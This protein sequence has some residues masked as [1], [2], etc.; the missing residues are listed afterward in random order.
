MIQQNH[1]DWLLNENL[2][3]RHDNWQMIRWNIFGVL[4]CCSV[5][6]VI[7]LY[8][9]SEGNTKQIIE[10]T[11][12]GSV[13]ASFLGI[14]LLRGLSKFPGVQGSTYI[15]P[16]L[17]TGYSASFI[18]FLFARIQYSRSVFVT[19]FILCAVWFYI[20]YFRAQRRKGLIIGI[21][22]EGAA[23][24]LTSIDRIEWRALTS[25]SADA[26][27]LSAIAADLR[28]DLSDDWERTLT[29]YALQ[30]LPVYHSKQLMESL[31]GRVELEHLSE[32]S[33]GSLSPVS[34]YMTL[35]HILDWCA[36]VVAILL[37]LPLLLTTALAIRIDSPGSP[38]FRQIRVGYRGRPFT[39]YKF[40]SM[41]VSR[42]GDGDARTSA[43]TGTGDQ[44]ITRIGR[45]LRTSRIDE[46]PQIINV[47][48]GEMSW[49]G[50][51]PEAE[52]LSRWYEA[53]IPFYRYRHIVRP[54]IT[55]WAQVNQ[56][57]VAE[58]EDVRHKLHYD[59]YYIRHFSLWLDILIVAR[60]FRTIA[61][62]FGAR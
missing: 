5:P 55:G 52:V 40:R 3:R 13:I 25:P 11:F 21:I 28:A 31:T 26:S 39:V 14:F 45:M 15:V 29:D 32:N 46:L 27:T 2:L 56:G 7:V 57:H 24:R 58:V 50:P 30:G 62:G 33:F 9:K 49:I 16:S 34:A 1:G 35:K 59:F 37:L 61:T 23:T 48:R 22:P 6:Y 54:G 18:I 60:T 19:S 53:E 8:F 43:M 20:A 44:R 12:I 4:L 17:L 36:A 47:L 51:R 42:D 38:I 41:T 10:A